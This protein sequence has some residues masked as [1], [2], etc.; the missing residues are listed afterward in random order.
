MNKL[1]NAWRNILQVDNLIDLFISKFKNKKLGHFYII[2]SDDNRDQVSNFVSNIINGITSKEFTTN[3]PDFLLVSPEKENY[4][5]EEFDEVFKF[6]YSRPW[7]LD[8]KFLLITEGQK[9][10]E[11]IINKLL[12]FLEEP[13]PYLTI[14]ISRPRNF[15]QLKTLESRGILTRLPPLSSE[16]KSDFSP[17][18]Q[19]KLNKE[20]VNEFLNSLKNKQQFEY[21]LKEVLLKESIDSPSANFNEHSTLLSVLKSYGTNKVYNGALYPEKID[22]L[23]LLKQ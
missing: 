21:F 6:S 22:S 16:L 20:S 3:H 23:D 8:H 4:L 2:E 17:D 19:F 11:I 9:L 5:T 18:N 13:P 10:T 14:F 7:E 12:K 1:S 15:G